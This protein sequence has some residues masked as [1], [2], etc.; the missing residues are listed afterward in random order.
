MP[1]TET[2][3]QVFVASP[4]DVAEER[5]VLEEIIRELNITW[6]DTLGIRLD[7]V[8]WETHASPGF[9]DDAQDFINTQIPV[10]YDI[11]IGIMWT[12]FGTPTNRAGSGTV[13]EFSRAYDRHTEDPNSVE[14]MFYFKNALVSPTDLDPDQ[15]R[16]ISD[17]RSRLGD[18]GGLYFQFNSIDEFRNITRLHLSRSVQKRT[19]RLEANG[20]K[21]PVTTQPEIVDADKAEPVEEEEGFLDLIESANDSMSN[22]TEVLTRMTEATQ[23]LGEKFQERA[24]EANKLSASDASQN[25]KAAKRVAANAARDLE[26]FVK[27]MDVEIPL[28][29]DSFTTAMDSFGRAATLT[30]DFGIDNSD[31]LQDALN[32]VAGFRS[33]ITKSHGQIQGF[34]RL[35]E[36]FPRMAT[37]FNR[38]RRNAITTLDKLLDEVNVSNRQA[39]DVETLLSELIEQYKTN[40]EP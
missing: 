28:Y 39:N 19:K 40:G 6:A 34:R 37:V 11:F 29:S 36:D 2:I 16:D 24:E 1:K 3:L 23:E 21:E 5:S 38:A 14:I 13:E 9:G 8:R 27:R 30:S 20:E 12:R 22:V 26:D 33:A 7:L 10:S 35:I 15:L 25:L 32:N 4:D 17:F 31:D 18:L